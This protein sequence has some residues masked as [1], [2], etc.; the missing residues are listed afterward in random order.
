MCHAWVA[1]ERLVVGTDNGDLLLFESTG[2][3]RTVL[4]QSPSESH[5]I[6]A[7]ASFSKGFICGVGANVVLVYE[8]SDDKDYYKKV[9]TIQLNQGMGITGS[10]TGILLLLYCI[11]TK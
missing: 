7:L 3:F 6:T 2:E 5:P 8:K 1:E 9:R 4:P 11:L 10:P